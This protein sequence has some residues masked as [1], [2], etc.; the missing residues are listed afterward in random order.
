MKIVN[1]YSFKDG[2]K[3]VK[4]KHPKELK[5][6][7]DA[8]EGLDAILCLTKESKEKTKTGQILFSP[9]DLNNYLKLALH[10]QRVGRKRQRMGRKRSF[11]NRAMHSE[12]D[13]SVKWTA[14][15]TKS[16]WKSNSANMRSWVMTSS[17]R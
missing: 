3:F 8:I 13:D 7:I 17:L 10:T 11:R 9:V 14:S 16:A 15:K 5:E 4:Q 6:I 2:E 12:K 1:T